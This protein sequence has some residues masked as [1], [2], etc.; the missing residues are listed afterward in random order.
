MGMLLDFYEVLQDSVS[1]LRGLPGCLAFILHVSDFSSKVWWSVGISLY[2]RMRN[3][4]I[5]GEFSVGANWWTSCGV[6]RWGPATF[7]RRLSVICVC[8]ASL[9]QR[10][11]FQP[12]TYRNNLAASFLGARWRGPEDSSPF[13]ILTCTRSQFLPPWLTNSLLCFVATI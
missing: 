5:Y 2:L 3:L 9:S 6:I 13:C 4:N 1:L 11:I 8:G 7:T 12:L 10:G